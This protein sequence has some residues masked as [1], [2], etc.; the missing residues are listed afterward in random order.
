MLK[1]KLLLASAAMAAVTT[2]GCGASPVGSDAES[3]RPL[4]GG[5]TLGSGHRTG[6]DSAV[7]GV[8]APAATTTSLSGETDTRSGNLFGSGT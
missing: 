8:A 1:I 7:A 2:A 6:G 4:F 3:T 5:Q